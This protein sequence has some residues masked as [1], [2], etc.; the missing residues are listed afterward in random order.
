MAVPATPTTPSPTQTPCKRR[1]LNCSP[2]GN[3]DEAWSLSESTQKRHLKDSVGKVGSDGSSPYDTCTA[4]QLKDVVEAAFRAREPEILVMGHHDDLSPT[5]PLDLAKKY[6][7]SSGNKGEEYIPPGQPHPT[8]THSEDVVA[9]HASQ[10]TAETVNSAAT[11]TLSTPSG[12]TAD[13]PCAKAKA[14]AKAKPKLRLASR[15]IR[16]SVIP[17]RV[18]L[19]ASKQP[20]TSE[21]ACSPQGML[22]HPFM[23]PPACLRKRAPRAERLERC[24]L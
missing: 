2:P 21:P 4:K 24:S 8:Q 11:K 22:Q 1:F 20:S 16:S 10:S 12:A 23:S 17:S 6:E 5:R 7:G 19:V 18:P 14:K 9:A 15:A 3:D 13:T